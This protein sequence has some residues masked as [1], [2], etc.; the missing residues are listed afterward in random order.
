MNTT[1]IMKNPVFTPILFMIERGI[2]DSVHNATATGI[3]LN[4]S[5]IRSTLNKVRNPPSGSWSNS[6]QSVLR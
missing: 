6:H 2:L 4:D 3:N 5:H 1:D